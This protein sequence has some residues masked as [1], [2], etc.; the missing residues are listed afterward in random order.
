M[1]NCQGWRGR[2]LPKETGIEIEPEVLTLHEVMNGLDGAMIVLGR[3]ARQ[4]RGLPNP[5]APE[6]TAEAPLI[7]RSQEL[8]SEVEIRVGFQ[9]FRR[10]GPGKGAVPGGRGG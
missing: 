3:A 7:D 5:S 6:E 4:P 9:I 2:D 8:G 10:A 1:T